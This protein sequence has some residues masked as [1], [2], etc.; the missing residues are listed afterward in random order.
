[1]RTL[2]SEVV[3]VI[4]AVSIQAVAMAQGPLE[5]NR[6]EIAGGCFV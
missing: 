2:T 4:F 6:A 5:V 1:M 3:T